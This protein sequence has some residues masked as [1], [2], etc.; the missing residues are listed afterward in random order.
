MEAVIKALMGAAKSLV[1][2]VILVIVLMPMLI[3]LETMSL[4]DLKTV[5]HELMPLIK[6]I[7]RPRGAGSG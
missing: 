3:L 1:H 6:N 5:A 2:P 4:E 7:T